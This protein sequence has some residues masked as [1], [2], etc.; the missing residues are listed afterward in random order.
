VVDLWKLFFYYFSSCARHTLH[1]QCPIVVYLCHKI[2]VTFVYVAKSGVEAAF[3]SLLSLSFFLDE[4]NF[5]I[6]FIVCSWIVASL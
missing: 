6:P 5:L 1:R 2:F 4:K 3:L